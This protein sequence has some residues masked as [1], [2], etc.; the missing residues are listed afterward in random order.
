MSSSPPRFDIYE[1]L[2]YVTIAPQPDGSIIVSPGGALGDTYRLD[3]KELGPYVAWASEDRK[4]QDRR[5]W[6]FTVVLLLTIFLILFTYPTYARFTYLT[7]DWFTYRT[8][9]WLPISTVFGF[10]WAGFLFW[11]PFENQRTT[12][13]FQAAFPDAPPWRDESRWRR[14]TIALLVFH[15]RWFHILGSVICMWMVWEK[16]GSLALNASTY[17]VAGITSDLLLG[18]MVAVIGTLNVYLTVEQFRFRRR[19]G[20]APDTE[21]FGPPL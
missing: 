20:R 3:E 15:P 14:W 4:K 11:F 12:R 9:I 17:S 10:I 2:R 19:Y 6:L 7:Y 13:S 18:G 8:F 21:D 16:A 1:M 5:G